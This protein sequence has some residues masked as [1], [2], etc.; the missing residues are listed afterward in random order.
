LLPSALAEG[1]HQ[2]RLDGDLLPSMCSGDQKEKR[3]QEE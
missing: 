1:S 2:E 3:Y